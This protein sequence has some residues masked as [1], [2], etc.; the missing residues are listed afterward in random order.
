MIM[1]ARESGSTRPKCSRKGVTTSYSS[2][3]TR[4]SWSGPRSSPRAS[5]LALLGSVPQAKSFGASAFLIPRNRVPKA[6]H[7]LRFEPKIPRIK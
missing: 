2:S 5:T 3:R 7:S 4:R 1:G 6:S